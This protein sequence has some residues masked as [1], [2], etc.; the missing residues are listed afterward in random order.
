MR[1]ISTRWKWIGSVLAAGVL[2]AGP[3]AA[4]PAPAP[5]VV[6]PAE[7]AAAAEEAPAEEAYVDPEMQ[8]LKDRI[9]DLELRLDEATTPKM[10]KFPVR[11]SGYADLGW[12]A[13]TGDGSGL[14][15]D[16]GYRH[17]PEESQFGW[18]FYGDIFATH[19]N[20]R[21]D[22]AD[23][24][25]LPGVNR[26]DSVN[27][28][29]H[30]TFLVNEVN[31]TTT[32]GL[33]DR[34]ILVTSVNFLPRQGRDF[35]LG[36]F[37]EVDLAQLEWQPTEDQKTSVWFGKFES[38]FGIEYK[39]RK[40]NQ[41][42]GLTPSLVHRYTSGTNIGVKVRS[43]LFNEKIIVAAAATNGSFGVEEFHFNN[44]IDANDFKTLTGRLAGVLPLG[45]MKL[46]IG[47]SGQYGTTDFVPNGGDAAHLIGVDAELSSPRFAVRAQW[48][49][50]EMPGDDSARAYELD[51]H[52]SGYAEIA[53]LVTPMIGVLVRGDLRDAR[54]ALGDERLYL[55]KSWRATG[56]LR[57]VLNPRM[58]VKAEYLHNGEYGGVPN[59]ANDVVTSSLVLS[60]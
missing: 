39:T 41:R 56:G 27:S 21:G 22:A 32:A 37:M 4:Q 28:E 12:F 36:D 38:V 15:Q 58:L 51:L 48:M 3:A 30:N 47:F 10:A 60:Y 18:V 44:E 5:D 33:S 42:F 46:E 14:R 35:T 57:L 6:P 50:G 43:K 54:V 13:T 24:G 8:S 45:N 19:V 20:S 59:F 55:T 34:A 25:E 23:L 53:Y 9:A 49:Q 2:Y 52:S 29:G 11:F 26:F 17:F 7:A 40:S 1:M 16:Y 31:F